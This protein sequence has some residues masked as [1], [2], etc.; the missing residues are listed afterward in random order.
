MG[1][2]L[3]VRCCR[4]AGD[5]LGRWKEWTT[6]DLCPPQR[7]HVR[8]QLWPN[9]V[10]PKP[11]LAKTNFAVPPSDPERPDPGRPDHP[12]RP[13]PQD[14]PPPKFR[15][16]SLF[17]HNFHYFFPLLGVF[18]LNFGGVFEGRGRQM[19][20]FRLWGCRAKP[21]RGPHP[22]GAPHGQP[23]HPNQPDPDRADP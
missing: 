7:D 22:F 12:D 3:R 4:A 8:G 11:S 15:A 13:D 18:S 9:R 5:A 20:T 2:G 17:R 23:P 16:L 6:D 21:R 1:D 10:W 14:R 19:C